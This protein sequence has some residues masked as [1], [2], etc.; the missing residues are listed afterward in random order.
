MSEPNIYD[1]MEIHANGYCSH[2]SKVIVFNNWNRD[3]DIGLKCWV[4]PECDVDIILFNKG[5]EN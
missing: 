3:D 5:K 4:C 2:C 1:I